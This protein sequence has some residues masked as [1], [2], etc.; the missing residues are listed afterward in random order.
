MDGLR[1]ARV[2][3]LDDKIADAKPLM[4]ALAKHGIGATYF[5]GDLDMLP[6]A[7]RKLTG[8][9]LAV[10]D[11]DLGSGGEAPAVISALLR[12][13]NGIVRHDNGPY[14]AIAWTDKEEEYFSEFVRRQMELECQP[15][16]VIKMYKTCLR[17]S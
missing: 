2:L 13:V 11:L 14:L 7:D 6:C 16:H 1:T 8:I 9:R 17:C 15:I 3:V 10:L 4:E 12:T 5:S